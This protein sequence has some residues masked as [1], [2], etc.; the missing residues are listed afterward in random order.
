MKRL[1]IP[2]TLLVLATV[3]VQAQDVALPPCTQEQAQQ[4]GTLFN[5]QIS[6]ALDSASG[7]VDLLERA[8]QTSLVYEH[9]QKN[10]V[11]QLPHC[12]QSLEFQLAFERTE[13]TMIIWAIMTRIAET[14]LDAG[15]VEMAERLL[16]RALYYDARFPIELDAL[17]AN[18]EKL[19]A[20]AQGV[21]EDAAIQTSLS[22]YYVNADTN[23][24]IRAC[25]NSECAIVTTARPGQELRV[26][27]D[28]GNWYELLLD[29]GSTAYIAS[30]LAS[31]SPPQVIPRPTSPPAPVQPAQATPAPQQP[32]G[33]TR[34]PKNCTEARE[35][36]LSAVEAAQ[37]SHLD[38]DHDGVACYGD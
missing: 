5:E 24:N 14:K 8:E 30:F 23:V 37:W 26:V 17:R 4:M 20:I 3:Q 16:N 19:S 27:D 11:P 2:L 6:D 13:N 18:A 28:T 32:S 15:E 7:K 22:I 10:I 31:K 33:N 21:E 12:R 29:D 1:L 35:M 38:R 34:R 25:G 36:G 9:W